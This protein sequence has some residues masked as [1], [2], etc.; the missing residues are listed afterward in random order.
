VLV[1]GIMIHASVSVESYDVIEMILRM[2]KLIIQ[3]FG[4]LILVIF[5]ILI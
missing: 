1:Y 4:L 2:Q 5:P 3:T